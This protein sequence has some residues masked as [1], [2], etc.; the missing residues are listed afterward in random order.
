MQIYKNFV[1]ER[2]WSSNSLLVGPTTHLFGCGSKSD[3]SNTAGTRQISIDQKNS[4]ES[5]Q[6][7]MMGTL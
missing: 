7:M 5:Y 2:R 6:W 1:S 4:R 3:P